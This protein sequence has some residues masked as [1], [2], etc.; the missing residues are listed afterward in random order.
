MPPVE[1]H[2]ELLGRGCLVL[3]HQPLGD[4][5]GPIPAEVDPRHLVLVAAVKDE[6]WRPVRLA[7]PLVIRVLVG[8]VAVLPVLQIH[9]HHYLPIRFDFGVE[10]RCPVPE[11]GPDS[12]ASPADDCVA[13]GE[14]LCAPVGQRIDATIGTVLPNLSGGFA[15]VVELV[16]DGSRKV[17]VRLDVVIEHENPVGLPLLRI[18]LQSEGAV[19]VGVLEVAEPMMGAESPHDVAGAPV[20]LDHAHV[21]E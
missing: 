20:D 8:A 15:L 4:G 12:H 11:A 18:V 5:G 10:R 14:P 7:P 3:V 1:R 17:L 9:L 21:P 2:D 13:I 6:G 19:L 16:L